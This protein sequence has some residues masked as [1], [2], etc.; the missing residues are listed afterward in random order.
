MEYKGTKYPKEC[1][2]TVRKQTFA[3][4]PELYLATAAE[5]Y[6]P[7]KVY[8]QFSRFSVTIINEAKMAATANIPVQAFAGIARK[9]QAA[10]LIDMQRSILPETRPAEPSVE[11][12]GTS[13]AFTVRITAGKLKGRT[14]ADVLMD[15]SM[16]GQK[17]LEHQ[18]QWLQANLGQYPVNQ[19]QIDAINDAFALQ[20]AGKLTPSEA[21]VPSIS[22]N[23]RITLYYAPYRALIRKQRADGKCP[24]YDVRIIW[25]F[26]RDYP[27]EVRILN[28]Y[29]PV[30]KNER[31]MIKVQAAQASD[32]MDCTM[33]L[34]EEEWNDALRAME[35]SMHQFEVF[36]ARDCILDAMNAD[37]YN[38][39][40]SSKGQTTAAG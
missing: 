6:S 11:A 22:Q 28:Y 2:S 13:P 27:V 25:N 32:K 10:Q 5:G 8:N 7:L 39:E 40:H 12:S 31:G 30:T 37:R 15:S 4:A 26:G 1:F 38:R 9:S 18:K 20:M 16:D 34:L 36:H 17:F 35:T 29:A 3:I 33:Q 24:V 19:K 23:A 21:S 14:P